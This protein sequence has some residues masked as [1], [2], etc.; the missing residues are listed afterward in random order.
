MP[1][2]DSAQTSPEMVASIY[3][4]AKLV[5]KPVNWEAEFLQVVTSLTVNALTRSAGPM[6]RAAGI[7]K[8]TKAP[9]W[10]T[11]PLTKTAQ[12]NIV[13]M[14]AALSKANISQA[15]I[16]CA[17][18]ALR[19]IEAHNLERTLV[20][21]TLAQKSQEAGVVRAQLVAILTYVGSCNR[22]DAEIIAPYLE[23]ILADSTIKVRDA[24]QTASRRYYAVAR[25]LAQQELAAGYL[26][27]ISRMNSYA[28]KRPSIAKLTAIDDFVVAYTA[29]I[30]ARTAELIPQHFDM[31]T[32]VPIDQLYVVPN[33][34]AKA[35]DVQ[36]TA[37]MSTNID[38]TSDKIAFTFHHAMRR[39]YRT[40]V[41]GSPGAGKTTLTQKMMHDLCSNSGVS[42]LCIPFLIT[43]RKYEQASDRSRISVAK[44]IADDIVSELQIE[45]PEGAI[46]YLL[47][48]GRA[49]AIFDGLDELLHIE[50][51]RAIAR[52]VESFGRRYPESSVVVTSRIRGYNEVAL[53]SSIYTHIYLED[54]DDEGVEEYVRKWYEAN[55]RLT[56]G[57]KQAIVRDFMHDS[58][59]ATDLRSNPLLLS[60]MCNIYKGA[61][62]IPQNRSDLYER[63]ATMLFDEWDQSRGIESGGPV[64]GDAYFALQDIAH[65][66]TTESE[67]ATGIPE[68]RLKTRLTQFLNK[69][70][71]GNEV[72]ANE[73]ASELLRLWR[74]RAWILTD[75]GSDTL[76]SIYHFTHRTFLEYFAGTY[77]ARSSESPAKLW[78]KLRPK[79]VS[80]EWD[81]VAQIALQTYGNYRVG[82]VDEVYQLIIDEAQKLQ[83]GAIEALVFV[84]RNLDALRPGPKVIR[85]L[86]A[87]A[88]RLVVL[89]TLP[90]F[91]I[92][93]D[94]SE[95][96]DR[97][98]EEVPFV[99]LSAEEADKYDD[100]P[101]AWPRQCGKVQLSVRDLDEPLALIFKSS[102][103]FHKI[104]VPMLLQLMM[105]LVKES[106]PK[107]ASRGM[108]LTLCADVFLSSPMLDT[109]DSED[110]ERKESD[111]ESTNA[112]TAQLSD[113]TW[114][115]GQMTRLVGESFWLPIEAV[116]KGIWTA[117]R[118]IRHFGTMN[119]LFN[120]E[121]AF[122]LGTRNRRKC[123]AEDILI[124]YISGQA[125]GD[126]RAV[127]KEVGK[128]LLQ[129]VKEGS[130]RSLAGLVD[131][132]WFAGSKVSDAIIT[133]H[134][135]NTRYEETK[136]SSDVKEEKDPDVVLGAGVIVCIFVEAESW[137]LQD[138][139]EDQLS[140]LRLGP[141]QFLDNIIFHRYTSEPLLF[142]QREYPDEF[143]M[144][145][146]NAWAGRRL[147]LAYRSKEGA[148][149]DI[150]DPEF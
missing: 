8:P 92:Q 121:S 20:I 34:Y 62:Y 43:L 118:C 122:D 78:R 22:S 134:Y 31:Q 109:Q 89:Y 106:D 86:I 15:S 17:A 35:K 135:L 19:S 129:R 36:R 142:S 57:E 29:E 130:V 60:L 140:D 124:R 83:L 63:C 21:E 96:Q 14:L 136:S 64:R 51:R 74:G 73:A 138:L 24:I 56:Q 46:E 117:E 41:L 125:T 123:F 99:E 28:S 25:E 9:E 27:D 5:G 65:W 115:R 1:L 77:L 58:E 111:A 12:E 107:M 52:A 3:D 132:N 98:T 6:A 66:A 7:I 131:K 49:V 113:E 91:P 37:A 11:G 26:E 54:L 119:C 16:S 101:V 45:V 69:T 133:S 55:P 112:I 104:A 48:T 141:I 79:T 88:L 80:G 100:D 120:A 94:W 85:K 103:L 38:L 67:L 84:C 139:S 40:V 71:Y 81:V 61:G 50:R 75:V 90:C 39:M 137:R 108:L 18:R 13:S 59:T 33:F 127:L 144:K 126:D 143:V 105:E 149:V 70:R 4:R 87:C 82:A 102:R 32:R 23:S 128:I 53:K 145:V 76:H 42:K 97:Q 47:K 10:L 148:F 116:R 72:D 2:V 93:P 68:N 44:Y 147:S 114:V 150:G 110:T 95:Y 30:E 146:F